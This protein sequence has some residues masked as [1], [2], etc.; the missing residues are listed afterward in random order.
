MKLTYKK[1]MGILDR[2]LRVCIGI[3]LIVTG[4]LLVMETVGVVLI[5]LSIPLLI[6]G[7][8]GFCPLYVPLGISTKRET[9]NCCN[10]Y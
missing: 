7:I 3:I 8:T 1:N 10:T 2:M 9:N 6:S 5:I 4:M